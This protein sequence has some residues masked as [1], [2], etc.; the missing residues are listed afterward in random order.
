MKK[1]KRVEDRPS[2]LA[3]KTTWGEIRVF[4]RRGRIVEC[5]LPTLKKEPKA[6]FD[7]VAIHIAAADKDDERVL[8]AAA[9]FIE[10]AFA[11]RPARPPA[12]EWPAAT[13]FTSDVW[14]ALTRIPAGKTVEYGALAKAVGR[15]RA[16]RAVGRAC[17]A[18]RLPVF[19]PCHRVVGKS[20]LTGFT[21]G[22][23]WKRLLL[24]RERRD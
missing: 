11:G 8:K 7:T 18:N 3:V 21:G 4:A 10:K 12:F 17:G 20:G 5:L 23:A 15:P 2:C 16:S 24:E 9:D 22:L 6:P 1:T 19:V 13:P 14:R